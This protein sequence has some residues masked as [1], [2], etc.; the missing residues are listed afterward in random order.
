MMAHDAGTGLAVDRICPGR[1]GPAPMGNVTLGA[2][3][4]RTLSAYQGAD[5]ALWA[6]SVL[7]RPGVFPS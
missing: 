3:L 6:R 7:C 5:A 2:V 4:C 1:C